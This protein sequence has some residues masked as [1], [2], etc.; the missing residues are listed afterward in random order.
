M[1]G[2]IVRRGGTISGAIGGGST[3]DPKKDRLSQESTVSGLAALAKPHENALTC[4]RC[5]KVI[6]DKRWIRMENGRG[7]L[8]DK[9]WKN[10]YLPKVLDEWLSSPSP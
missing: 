4:I 1:G 8:C 10:M 2:I 5:S 7:V 9:C 3:D 6:E